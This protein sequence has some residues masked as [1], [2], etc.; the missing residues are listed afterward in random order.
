MQVQPS[1]TTQQRVS[2]EQAAM[3][4]V[5]SHASPIL[6]FYHH[7]SARSYL[8][9]AAASQYYGDFDATRSG[10]YQG[11]YGAAR[12]GFPTGTGITSVLSC[13]FLG[14]FSVTYATESDISPAYQWRPKPGAIERS[15]SS[16]HECS[17]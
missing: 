8:Y 12:T 5:A 2:T 10:Q 7:Q 14:Y 17:D 13:A 4:L 3:Q 15:V 6:L 1:S 11:G 9:L 16:D